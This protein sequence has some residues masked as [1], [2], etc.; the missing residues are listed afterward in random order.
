[1]STNSAGRTYVDVI[2]R[3]RMWH[4]EVHEGTG[5][6]L[7]GSYKRKDQARWVGTGVAM[8]LECEVQIRKRNGQFREKNSYGNDPRNIPG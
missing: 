7:F 2:Y 1:M 3:N 4:V 8:T 6:T 5:T